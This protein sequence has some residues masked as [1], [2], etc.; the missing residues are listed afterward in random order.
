MEFD[1]AYFASMTVNVTLLLCLLTLFTSMLNSLPTSSS[2]RMI[3]VWVVF[4]LMVPFFE[5]TLQSLLYIYKLDGDTKKPMLE[6]GGAKSSDDKYGEEN[7]REKDENKDNDVVEMEEER[8][9]WNMQLLKINFDRYLLVNIT[10][11]V[12]PGVYTLFCFIFFL[13]GL[14]LADSKQII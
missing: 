1:T 9:I 4:N 3:D 8:E 13:I 12:I 2:V 7:K 5:I 6:P 11:F 10:K 14:L